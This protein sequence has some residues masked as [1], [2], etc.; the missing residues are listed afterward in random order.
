VAKTIKVNAG[1]R[2]EVQLTDWRYLVRETRKIEP[3]LI[4]NFKANATRIARP[5]DKAI[6]DGIP[7]RIGI[8]G[9]QPRV[10]PGRLTWGNGEIEPKKTEI[11]ADTRLRKKGK[12]IA[13]VWVMSPAVAIFDT[14][15]KS[16]RHDGK[17]TKEYDYSRSP[18]G[19]RT[20]LR[21]G[22]GSH[23][24]DA[25]NRSPARKAVTRSRL[26]YP[27]A[28]KALPQANSEIS[29]LMEKTAQRINSEI[30]RNA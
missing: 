22:Q 10:I 21:N 5:V 18:T 11:R 9:M 24:V 29:A 27:L 1:D 15:H 12:S 13:S 6:R 17:Q 28:L 16:G 26:V 4:D 14:A 7:N 20:H 23:M 25:I 2:V 3:A 19:K 8:K 30:Q